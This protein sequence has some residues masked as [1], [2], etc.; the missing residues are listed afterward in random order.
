MWIFFFWGGVHRFDVGLAL[1]SL[2][3]VSARER[4]QIS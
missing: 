2:G 3:F 1:A 4:V